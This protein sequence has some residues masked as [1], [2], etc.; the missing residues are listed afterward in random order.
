MLC[1]V[2]DQ[3]GNLYDGHYRATVA[4]DG[5][6]YAAVTSYTVHNGK[7]Y[8]GS[9]IGNGTASWTDWETNA[10]ALGGHLVTINDAGEQQWIMDQFGRLSSF[11]IGLNDRAVEGT[12]AWVSGEAVGYNNWQTGYPRVQGNYDGV[13]FEPA[14]AGS[15]TTIRRTTR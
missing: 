3:D 15:G 14:R 4:V 7:M 8:V 9:L 5:N 12:F 10:V 2:P 6:Y 1:V 13:Y 11:Y